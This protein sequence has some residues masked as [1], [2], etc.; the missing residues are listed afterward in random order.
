[1]ARLSLLRRGHDAFR[2]GE[3]VVRNYS[4]RKP[5]LFAVSRFDPESRREYVIAFN[6]SGDTLDARI[7]IET[8]SDRF[9]ALEG[10]CPATAAAPG[11]YRLSLPPLGFA[12]CAAR[13]PQ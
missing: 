4:E 7:E 2:R 13:S 3:Q 12:V 5:G 6:T 1:M 9:E 10:D 8:S 11:A